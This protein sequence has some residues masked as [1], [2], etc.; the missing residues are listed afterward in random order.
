MSRRNRDVAVE[1]F[2]SAMKRL[3]DWLPSIV[4]LAAILWL[5]LVPHPFGDTEVPLFP[6]ADKIVHGLMFFGLTLCLNFDMLRFRHWHTLR[7]PIV[8]LMAL[9]S[10][11]TGIGIEFLQPETGRGQEFGDM[12]ADAFGA[13]VAGALWVMIGGSLGLTD[14][15][16]AREKD[17]ADGEAEMHSN[18]NTSDKNER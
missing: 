1:K 8:A 5:T 16:R 3:P 15:E 18:E 14:G 4:C 10:M 9:V 12:M 6:G 13:I 7:L 17:G 11:L 2:H